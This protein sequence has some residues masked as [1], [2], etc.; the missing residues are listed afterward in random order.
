MSNRRAVRRGW[1]SLRASADALL[2]MINDILDY[3]RLEADQIVIEAVDFELL[4]LLDQVRRAHG[5]VAASKGLSLRMDI[6]PALPHIVRGDH[7][8]LA[9]VL[10]HLVGNAIKFSEQGK[11]KLRVL[12]DGA[13]PPMLRFEVE[14]Q[15]VGIPPERQAGMF[16][17]F[18]Q[19]DN[20]TTRRFGGTGLGLQLCRRLV[21]L[22]AGDIG[23]A[24][25]PGLGSVFWFVVPLVSRRRRRRS[26]SGWAAGAGRFTGYGCVPFAGLARRRRHRS[27]GALG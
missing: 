3:S 17:L 25:K 18:S 4:G 1:K 13:L 12:P 23:F 5:P 27:P 15:G 8:R 20:S 10:A 19:G 14:D 21:N 7:V 16:Q 9:Q 11:I 6:S 26:C 22:M 2:R 24:S